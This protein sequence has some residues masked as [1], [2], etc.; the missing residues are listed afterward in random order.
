MTA[1]P[2]PVAHS[3]HDRL[4]RLAARKRQCLTRRVGGPLVFAAVAL[5]GVCLLPGGCTRAPL[6][7]TGPTFTI[8]TYN[9]NY[10]MP[11]ADRTLAALRAADADIVC[12]QETT[13]AWERRLRSELGDRYRY[14]AFRHLAGAGGLGLLSKVPCKELLYH[15]CAG[16]WHPG[17][18]IRA[19]TPAGPV[20]ILNVHLHPA[21]ALC[22]DG[23]FRASIRAYFD[24]IGVR[25]GQIEE[26]L[27]LVSAGPPTL[28][29]GDFNEPEDGRAVTYARGTRQLRSA[30]AEF[31]PWAATWQAPRR[32]FR[33]QAR[34][35]HI[36]Y[37]SSLRCLHA[38]V[39]KG[40]GS[41]H[42]P[43]TAAFEPAR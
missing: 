2:D 18:L 26:L 40:G 8:V 31:D 30:L 1:A 16:T 20:R 10:A 4:L 37:P 7:A 15:N 29:V 23:V 13:P 17:W 11:Q 34:I 43:V 33:P 19:D 42:R 28:V 6:K 5:V 9:V 21:K 14:M 35:D 32:L 3:V 39:V 22:P 41:D 38:G 36:L 12:L 24:A 25:R 27:D